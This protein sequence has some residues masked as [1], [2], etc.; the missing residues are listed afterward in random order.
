MSYTDHVALLRQAYDAMAAGD[1]A[2]VV[3]AFAE[4]GILHVATDGPFGGDHKGHEAIR[5]LL[6]GLFEWTGGTLRMEVQEIFA[7][8]EHGVTLLT[9]TA[10]RAKDGA[11][12]DLRETHLCRFLNGRIVELWDI[13]APEGKADHDAFFS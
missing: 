13:P 6:G 10:T 2:T 9:E 4:D 11:T 12:L 5:R 7:D 3:A 8:E 1:S